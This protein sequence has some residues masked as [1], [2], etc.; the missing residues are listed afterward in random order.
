MHPLAPTIFQYLKE[1]HPWLDFQKYN[2]WQVAL[3][4]TGCV[5][6]LVCYID[7]ILDIIRK[8]MVNIPVAAVLL[9][10]GWEIAACLF[11]VPDMGK[12]LV[13]AYWAW[14]LCDCFIFY[15]LFRFGYKQMMI[16]FFIKNAHFFVIAGIIISFLSQCTFMLQY[17]LPLAPLTG[18][19]INLVMSISFL[20]LLFVPGFNGYSKVTAW[21]KFLGTGLISIMFL[22]KYP[23]NYFLIILYIS[24]ALFDILYIILLNKK[25]SGKE[26]VSLI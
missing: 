23:D 12:L 11:F 6:W 4:F 1:P 26:L 10:F 24:V 5:L 8:K 21:S 13:I 3:F 18:Y 17:D 14:L 25:L 7:T 22:T 9:N 2:G 16:S 19:M 15:S 20:Y